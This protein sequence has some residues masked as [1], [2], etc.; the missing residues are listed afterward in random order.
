MAP[1]PVTVSAGTTFKVEFSTALAS[2]TATRGQTFRARVASNVEGDSGIGIPADSEVLGVV[3]EA[4]PAQ[5]LNG[6]A[7]LRLQ[8]TD[9]VLPTGAT[10]PIRATLLEQGRD[11]GGKNAAVI[12]GT[13][14]GGALLGNIISRGSRGKGTLVGALLGAV[15][16]TLFASRA[17]G[18]DIVIKPGTVVDLRLDSA[19]E[20]RDR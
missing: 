2:D 6:R 14:A 12:G 18:E 1:A 13:T 19:V 15:A 17:E 8:F 9:L 10:I 7:A 4:Q 16:G 11:R 3:T 20:V 5:G